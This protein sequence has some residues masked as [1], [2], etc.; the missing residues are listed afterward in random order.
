VTRSQAMHVQEA[1]EGGQQ[2]HTENG[3]RTGDAAKPGQAVPEAWRNKRFRISVIAAAVILAAGVGF[4]AGRAIGLGNTV[5]LTAIPRPATCQAWVPTSCGFIEDDDLIAQDNQQNILETTG[6]GMV[7]VLAGGTSVGIGIV[8]TESGKV[9]TTYQPAAGAANLAAEYVLSRQTFKATVIGVDPVAGLALLQLQ[10]GNGRAFSTVTVGNSATLVKN[11]EASSESSYHV[12]G[13]IYDT[14]VGTTGREAALTIDVGTLAT[15]DTTVTVGGKAK[16]GLMASVLQSA[17]PS[18]VGGPLVNLN[19]QVIGIIVG[20][21]GGG[22]HIVGYAIPIN[23]AL[24]VATQID[25]G[26]S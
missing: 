5:I 11:A 12:P 10:G 25:D 8:L 20:G 19:G 6:P 21:S 24:A 4:G 2:N 23:T 14:A 13:E 3:A 16:S 1:D 18:A 15:L 7:H 26:N 17:L 9:L 22:L